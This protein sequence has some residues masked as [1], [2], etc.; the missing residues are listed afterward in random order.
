M[1]MEV[2]APS[3]IT[4]ISEVEQRPMPDEAI[5]AQS[6][7]RTLDRKLQQESHDAEYREQRNIDA[8]D[9]ELADHG[10]AP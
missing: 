5:E 10:I 8:I 4:K 3:R 7:Q 9:I 1:P 6:I 2:T